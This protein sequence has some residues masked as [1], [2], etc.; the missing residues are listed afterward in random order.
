M[1]LFP[2][3][4]HLSHDGI[5]RGQPGELRPIQERVWV[6]VNQP[7]MLICRASGGGGHGS[8]HIRG[9]SDG[10]NLVGEDFMSSATVRLGCDADMPPAYTCVSFRQ[11]HQLGQ[12]ALP[13]FDKHW[14]WFG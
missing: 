7:L 13:R 8:T 1:A 11:V 2:Y 5:L 14:L 10:P 12:R 6:V 9:S 4:V 3:A